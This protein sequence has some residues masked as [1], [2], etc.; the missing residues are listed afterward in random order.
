MLSSLQTSDEIK[1]VIQPESP[2]FSQ[3]EYDLKCSLHSSTARLVQVW[4]L[5]NPHLSDQFS[6]IS[7]VCLYACL[8]YHLDRM[9]LCL[10]PAT[11]SSHSLSCS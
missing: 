1:T 9:E 6:R 11:R 4:M 3:L 7:H 2:L 5:S 10:L 8:Y